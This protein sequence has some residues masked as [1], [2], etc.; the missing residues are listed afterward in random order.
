QRQRAGSA[1]QGQALDRPALARL[2]LAVAPGLEQ[3]RRAGQRL[4]RGIPGDRR[5][6]VGGGGGRGHDERWLVSFT[7]VTTV[8][9]RARWITVSDAFSIRNGKR[10]VLARPTTLSSATCTTPPCVT[11]STSPR[12]WRSRISSSVAVTRRSNGSARSPP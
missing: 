1:R 4:Q 2:D 7:A 11:Q 3:G 8:R 12:G 6:H 5:P 10:P 9:P